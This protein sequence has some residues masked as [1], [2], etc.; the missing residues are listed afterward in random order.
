M[1]FGKPE[2]PLNFGI[3]GHAVDEHLI[4]LPF[5]FRHVN[6]PSKVLDIG[7]TG[8]PASMLLSIL[9]Y[10]VTGIDYTDYPRPHPNMK[11]I[12]GDFNT[13]NFGKERFDIVLSMSAV[14]HFGLQYYNRSEPRDRQ[15]DVVA[16]TKVKEL[17]NKGGQLIFTCMYGIP[18]I[19][20]ESG[21][22]FA[23][24]YDDKSLD[25]L[26]STFE[27][28][29]TEYYMITDRKNVR[30]IPRE[31]AMASRHYRTSGTYAIACI[32]AAKL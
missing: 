11:F 26:L 2:A 20:T 7:C 28:K 27:I 32:N 8:S 12:K 29:N 19:V 9:R 31:E 10:N 4:A 6:N 18:E 3:N 21:R 14:C 24:V 22:P 23:R 1:L 16:M 13:H 5:L 15:A 25:V 30:Q 17:M